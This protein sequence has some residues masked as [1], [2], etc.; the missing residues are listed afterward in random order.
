MAGL[1]LIKD[2]HLV[3]ALIPSFINI[4][5]AEDSKYL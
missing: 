4:P 5:E 2:L 3:M 1:S